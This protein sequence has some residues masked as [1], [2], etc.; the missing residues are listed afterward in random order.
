MQETKGETDGKTGKKE[1][2]KKRK[3]EKK[4]KVVM[5]GANLKISTR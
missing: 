5:A 2:G 1:V 4:E 3:R